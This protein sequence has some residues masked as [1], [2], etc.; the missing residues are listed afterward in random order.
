MS[1]PQ[2]CNPQ[3][4]PLLRPSLWRLLGAGHN[5]MVMPRPGDAPLIGFVLCLA[6][7]CERCLWRWIMQEVTDNHRDTHRQ[8]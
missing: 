3:R 4:C 8:P 2:Q 7:S 6:R 5:A 1:T